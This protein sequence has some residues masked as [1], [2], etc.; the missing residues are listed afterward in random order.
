M[1]RTTFT[2]ST[3]ISTT[4]SATRSWSIIRS[5]TSND[6]CGAINLS[7]KRQRCI[8]VE[9]KDRPGAFAVGQRAQVGAGRAGNI[10]RHDQ[11]GNRF[12]PGPEAVRRFDDDQVEI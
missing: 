11:A 4:T 10:D 1:R 5:S 12:V 6:E 2:A 9:R 7:P 3:A 8:L